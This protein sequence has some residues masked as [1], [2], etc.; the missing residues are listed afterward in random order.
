MKFRDQKR[1]FRRKT[2][3]RNYRSELK[4]KT[5]ELPLA[6]VSPQKWETTLDVFYGTCGRS[7]DAMGSGE[8]GEMVHSGGPSMRYPSDSQFPSCLHMELVVDVLFRER[9]VINQT[10]HIAHLAFG[11]DRTFDRTKDHS[12]C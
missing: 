1:T 7:L 6:K 5:A 8:V 10:S 11:H 2:S 3:L 4:R 12:D 9:S